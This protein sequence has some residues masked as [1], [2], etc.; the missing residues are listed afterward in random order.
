MGCPRKSK[1]ATI[2]APKSIGDDELSTEPKQR[3][4][5]WFDT[6]LD[7]AQTA[8]Y[9]S[10]DHNI[11]GAIENMIGGEMEAQHELVKTFAEDEKVIGKVPRA[12]RP[13]LFEMMDEYH[14]PATINRD[15]NVPAA[16]K[17]PLIHLKKRAEAQ[18]QEIIRRKRAMMQ[19]VVSGWN[20]SQFAAWA[21]Q[22]GLG[23]TANKGV[24]TDAS[25]NRVSIA[26]ARDTVVMTAVPDSY[27]H[28]NEYILHAFAGAYRLGYIDANGNH[29]SIGSSD[30]ESFA[31]TQADAIRKLR[32]FRHRNPTIP[33]DRLVVK[34]TTIAPREATQVSTR[35]YHRLVKAIKQQAQI[36][37]DEVK[38]G[39]RGNIQQAANKQKFWGS[40]LQRKGAEGYSRDLI[41][42]WNLQTIGYVRWKHM[43]D[44]RRAAM[45]L[46][47]KVRASGK[48]RWAEHLE[49][50][51]DYVWGQ[52]PS[53][54][55]KDVDNI[56]QW[57]A[58]LPGVRE[59]TTRVPWLDPKPYLLSRKL[60][61]IRAAAFVLTLQTGRQAVLNRYHIVQTLWPIMGT[62]EMLKYG[63]VYKTDRGRALIAQ[64]G[65]AWGMGKFGEDFAAKASKVASKALPAQASERALQDQ[66]FVAVAAWAEDTMKM[67]T[68]QAARW[69]MIRGNSLAGFMFTKANRPRALRHPV[70]QTAFQFKQF[71]LSQIGLVR[72][73]VSEGNYGGVARWAISTT[74][75]GGL[76]AAWPGPKRV[77]IGGAALAIAAA[78]RGLGKDDEEA[79]ETANL[80]A[81][82]G[83]P[84]LVYGVSLSG[85]M[86][87]VPVPFGDTPYEAA[88]NWLFGPSVSYSVSAWKDVTGDKSP[89][90]RSTAMKVADSVLSKSPTVGQFRAAMHLFSSPDDAVQLDQ[91]GRKRREQDMHALLSK[92]FGFTPAEEADTRRAVARLMELNREYDAALTRAAQ[93]WNSGDAEG[94]AKAASEWNSVFPETP[95]VSGDIARRSR[96]IMQG[97]GR[98]AQERVERSVSR[99][100][101]AAAD[102]EAAR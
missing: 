10:K 83:L 88:G 89:V 93:A 78:L 66:I 6:W 29:Q 85:S 91:H 2:L 95:I 52:A 62:K 98:T 65:H 61:A 67:P 55:E 71:M 59:V 64:Y 5:S 73:M 101:R 72:W 17:A 35:T 34:P 22:H 28:Q 26:S 38:A 82:H 42:V 25:G 41:K 1:L 46:I 44:M 75:M 19:A 11:I 45:P 77:V 24:I 40:L 76:A 102:I 13:K 90:P 49:G 92:A 43:S 53:T 37:A 86:E 69:A 63:L 70:A 8:A 51:L 31:D 99:K 57:T 18:R 54:F 81:W 9:R 21:Q 100:A 27:G 7:R 84:G 32:D 20:T 23:W 39:L 60:S 68:D 15:P 3:D 33:I 47:E 4:I 12:L 96:A 16:L 56:A 48:P 74:A 14:D 30:T 87:V 58:L 50:I 94:C 36:G 79:K 97:S 80:L